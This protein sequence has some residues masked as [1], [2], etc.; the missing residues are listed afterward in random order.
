[1]IVEIVVVLVNLLVVLVFVLVVEVV[2]GESFVVFMLE[3]VLHG[4][5]YVLAAAVL[6]NVLV[7]VEV[8]ARKDG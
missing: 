1:M 2:T 7:F 6:T 5:V 8:K 3:I 4:V